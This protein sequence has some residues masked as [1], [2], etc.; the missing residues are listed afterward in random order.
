MDYLTLKNQA[1]QRLR[2]CQYDAAQQLYQQCLETEPKERSNSWYLGLTYLLQEQ[3]EQAEEVWIYLLLNAPLEEYDQWLGEFQNAVNEVAAYYQEVGYLSAARLIYEQVL[4]QFPEQGDSYYNLGK[5]LTD[6]G[7]L[8]EAIQQ[9]QKA[10]EIDPNQARYYASLG[11]TLVE[12]G[13]ALDAY[14]H[15]SKALTLDPQNSLYQKWWAIALN[16]ISFTQSHPSLVN[17]ILN[18]FKRDDIKKNNLIN[19]SLSLLELTT[20]F[21]NISQSYQLGNKEFNE[22]YSQGEF[23][24]FFNNKLLQALLTHTL[25]AS[26][27]IENLLTLI[28]QNILLNFDLEK[29]PTS[30]NLAFTCALAHQ[31]FNNEYI[32]S[33]TEAEIDKVDLLEAKINKVLSDLDLEHFFI[34]K[35]E[36]LLSIFSLYKPLY[37]LQNSKKL[38]QIPTKKWSLLFYPLLEKILI[39]YY[40]EQKIGQNLETL[41]NIEDQ[42]SLSVQAQYEENPYPR[43]LGMT[44]L[45]PKPI[46]AVFSNLFPYFEVPSHLINRKLEVLIAG[47]GTGAEAISTAIQYSNVNILAIDISSSSLAYAIRMAQKYQLD[48]ITFRQADILS[49]SSL[50]KKFDIISSTG[51]IHHLENPSIGFK[52]LTDLLIPSGLIRLG[53]YS[54]KAR[55]SIQTARDFIANSNYQPTPEGVRKCR[56]EIIRLAQTEQ[57]EWAQEIMRWYDFYSLSNC[58]DLIFHVCEHCFTIPALKDMMEHLNLN[59]LGFDIPPATRKLYQEMFSNDEKMTCLEKWNQLEEVY[60]LTFKSMYNFWCQKNKC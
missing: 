46:S 21:Q 12:K 28:R 18:C 11:E 27:K 35:L 40:Q 7:H 31:C 49:L 5:I 14:T 34:P 42:V 56:Q 41:T 60:P 6:Q 44:I 8:T 48:N 33:I 25:I 1:A 52:V 54:Q 24:E 50:G 4:K 51:V 58:R 19:A 23:R 16:S 20:D 17:Q 45:P 2:Q 22:G 43:W 39:N 53:L 55:Q 30:S 57:I 3:Q 13:E 37:K 10:I 59:F 9:Y 15:L 36:T 32:F 47:C 38:L 29:S 26:I